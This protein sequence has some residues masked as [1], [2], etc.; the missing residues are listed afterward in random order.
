[1]RGPPA[2]KA[3]SE[4]AS[5]ELADTVAGWSG[6]DGTSAILERG[7]AVGRYLVLELLGTG[8]MGAV[9]AAYDPELD[10]KV[11]VKL[12]LPGAG[13]SIGRARMLREAQA[14]ARLSHPN[15]VTVHDVG[16]RVDE[17]FV[18]ME[19][20][21]GDTLTAWLGERTRTTDEILD[22]FVQAGRGL[23]AAHRAGLVHRDFKPDNVLVGKDGRTRVVDFGLVREV[24]HPEEEPNTPVPSEPVL[25]M[26]LTQA[27]S[28]MGTPAYMA[29][30]QF[31]RRAT[32]ARS[33]QYSFCV[34]LF[35]AL[36][37]KLPFIGEDLASTA[38]KV[39]SGE[40]PE[41]A[42]E[43]KV[44]A[45]VRAVLRR[46]MSITPAARYPSMDALLA[47]LAQSGR[48]GRRRLLSVA[49]VAAVAGAMAI[50][51]LAGK[52][53]A[54]PPCAG[55]ADRLTGAW[56]VSR[57]TAV[58]RAFAA[59]GLPY[60]ADSARAVARS[61][62]RY[63]GDWVKSW[64][65]S[66]EATRVRGEQSAEMQDLRAAC[67]ARRRSELDAL[68]D[69]MTAADQG[70]VQRAAA[71]AQAL[72]PVAECDDLAALQAPVPP[73][74]GAA[75]RREVD[76]IRDEAARV[77]ALLLAGRYKDALGPAEALRLRARALAYRPVEAE[78]AVLVAQSNMRSGATEK[79]M[80][81]YREA[82]TAAT[83]GR[84]DEAAARILT[85][86]VQVSADAEEFDRGLEW[87]ALAEAALERIGNPP[88]RRASL[89]HVHGYLLARQGKFAEAAAEHEQALVIRQRISPSSFETSRS[90]NSV[91]FA[92]DEI[93]RYAEARAMA[94][95]AVAIQLAEL[96]PNHPEVAVCYNNLGNIASDEGDLARASDYYHR[97][98][99]IR[100][101]TTPAGD[102]PLNLS[103]VLNNLGIVAFDQRRWDDALAFHHRA[104]AIRE[105]I[106][107]DGPD[108]SV[109]I[110]N[111]AAVELER[112]HLREGLAGYRRALAIA[113]KKLGRDHPYV[114]DALQGIGDATRRLGQ[115]D[116]ALAAY[117]RALA[118]R[119]AG[120][121]PIELADVEFGLARAL[122]AKGQKQRAVQLA[123]AARGRYEGDP[124]ARRKLAELDD[125]LR[126]RP[127]R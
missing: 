100:E 115:L 12:V 107:P 121:R 88:Q 65:D 102:D 63:A 72:P 44:P 96:G 76:A 101:K 77:D 11:A 31:M 1:M 56:D 10:R 8:G 17:V 118:I 123:R 23:A 85:M 45:R 43:R 62:D 50:P 47:E 27:G 9:Y 64:R 125:W 21:D 26:E 36:Q 113:E 122:F 46:G 114:G 99:A 74:S 78:V 119:K 19:L 49:A 59:T 94:E 33:D 28:V 70:T 79:A 67:L 5:P 51:L 92:Y 91:A 15:V 35:E 93:G 60:A 104:L 52:G 116:E 55:G 53:S 75:A 16:T 18:A 124:A 111:I 40:V 30:E 105:R 29:P 24:E 89:H 117:Q 38:E 120:A 127:V 103:N 32:D 83:A 108:V 22:V 42:G 80:A 86:L 126:S 57:R 82:L 61:L 97:A 69:L 54:A 68:V 37:G 109:S 58:E 3:T 71:A 41:V 84:H 2:G 25:S 110:A 95:K 112:G 13:G 66:C 7:A 73:P 4:A 87:E 81:A 39:L 14:I 90:L 6:G 98:L 48:A 20:V 34:A 106:E